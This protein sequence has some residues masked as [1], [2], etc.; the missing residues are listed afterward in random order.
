MGLF[1]S[2]GPDVVN[3]VIDQNV[4]FHSQ[5]S[6]TSYENQQYG[7]CWNKKSLRKNI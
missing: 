2:K 5:K 1:Q 7:N 4:L 3:Q 6:S